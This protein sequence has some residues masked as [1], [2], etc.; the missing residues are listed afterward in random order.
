M[1]ANYCGVYLCLFH[2]LYSIIGFSEEATI[3]DSEANSYQAK[4]GYYESLLR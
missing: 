4:A 2:H 1:C 3:P